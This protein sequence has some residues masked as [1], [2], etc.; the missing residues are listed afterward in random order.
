VP[1]DNTTTTAIF[2]YGASDTAS[3]AMPT[4]PAYNDTATVTAFTTSLSNLH[5]VELPSAVDEDLFFTRIW[6]SVLVFYR[7]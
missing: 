1:F 4:L 7:S 6:I 2:D 5:A 3:P